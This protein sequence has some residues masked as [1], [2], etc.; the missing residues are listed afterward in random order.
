MLSNSRR[1]LAVV[2]FWSFTL[3]A[4]AQNYD[5][6]DVWQLALQHDPNFTAAGYE[7]DAGKEAL[8]QARA[9]LLPY[10]SA[11]A[12]AQTDNKR[13]TNLSDSQTNHRGLWSL[14]ISQP[15]IDI[16]AWNNLERAQ[17]VEKS[18]ELIRAMAY[19]DLM[20]RVAQ[21]YFNVLTA[22]DVLRALQAEKLAIEAQLKAAQ[23]NFELGSTTITDTHE[24]QARLDLLLAHEHEAKNH[25]QLSFDALTSI[26]DQEP[27]KL[28]ELPANAV[29]PQP[30]PNNLNVWVSQASEMDLAVI[31]ARLQTK[32]SEKQLDIEKSGHYPSL[33]LEAQTGSATDRG[34]Y[35]TRPNSGPRSIDSSV[36]VTLSVPLFTGGELSSK[37]R[38]QSSRLQ[39]HRAQY[40]GAK[41]MARQNTQQYFSGVVSGHQ[42]INALAAAEKS[43]KAALEANQLAYE[44]G[45]RIN[46]DVL[47]AQQQLYTTQRQ[48]SQARYDTLMQSLRLKSSSGTL[49]EDDLLAINSLLVFSN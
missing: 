25:L 12:G 2:L 46:I 19:Q 39:Q 33:K 35:G 22:Q 21:S 30:E 40:E 14:T 28:A 42:R 31:R 5:L 34:L 32:I 4:N 49:T 6:L 29:L 26:I 43:S 27:D 13:R 36:G 15:V 24:A 10:I 23:H 37:V 11:D 20:L 17:Y 1:L 45:V 3:T 8:P 18:S 16:A 9:K 41:R 44:V 47:N 7:S 48:L 38:E